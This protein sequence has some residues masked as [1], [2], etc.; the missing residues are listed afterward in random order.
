MT[1]AQPGDVPR[2]VGAAHRLLARTQGRA[3]AVRALGVAPGRAK[4]VRAGAAGV[5]IDLRLGGADTAQ[6]QGEYTE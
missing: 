5:E 3:N 6:D 1:T 4:V 2:S